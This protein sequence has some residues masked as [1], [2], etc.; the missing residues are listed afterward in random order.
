MGFA[1]IQHLPGPSRVIPLLIYF[2]FAILSALS[3]IGLKF[4]KER[5]ESTGGSR[6]GLRQGKKW[7][8]GE[9]RS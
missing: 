8:K 1:G 9:A 5:Q 3:R 6:Y 2:H 4:L 7:K